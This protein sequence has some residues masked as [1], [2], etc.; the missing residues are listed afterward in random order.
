M[1]GFV[2]LATADIFGQII[3]SCG[4]LVSSGK[5]PG[6][7]LNIL[8][9]TEHPFPPTADFEWMEVENN[10]GLVIRSLG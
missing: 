1:P 2:N 7:L 5:R 9:C 6:V 8:Q 4:G 10:P 3:L